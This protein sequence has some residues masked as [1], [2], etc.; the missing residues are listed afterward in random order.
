MKSTCIVSVNLV[1]AKLERLETIMKVFSYY[2]FYCGLYRETIL[3]FEIKR[4][5]NLS[6]LI[7]GS[8]RKFEARSTRSIPIHILKVM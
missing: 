4:S 3:D 7:Y 5:N 1:Q 2:I 8:Y 6:L